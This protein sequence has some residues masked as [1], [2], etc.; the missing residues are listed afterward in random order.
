MN[1]A[2]P[3]APRAADAPPAQETPWSPGRWIFWL[4]VVF[5]LHLGLFVGL[6]DRKPITPRPVQ[7]AISLQPVVGRSEFL[8]LLDPTV[9]AGPHLRGFA[10]STWLRAPHIPYPTFRWTEPPRFLALATDQLGTL[11][12]PQPQPPANAGREIKIVPTPNL[13]VLPPLTPPPAPASSAVRVTG[14]LATLKWE[15][16]PDN[17]PLIRAPDELTNTLIQVTV[18][19]S[20][21]V[22][23]PILLPPGSRSKD[24]D[25]RALKLAADARFAPTSKTP[26]ITMGLLIF[27][28]QPEPLTNSVRASTE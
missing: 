24:A 27:E 12:H 15:N 25:Q 3:D 28:W 5:A 1:A 18:D 23:S 16:R 26:Q 20:G 22:F 14:D 11:F 7:N 8:D 17:L 9:F 10:G 2:P 19:E 13:T 21:R 6:R 4:I